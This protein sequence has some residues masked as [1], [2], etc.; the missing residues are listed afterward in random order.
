MRGSRQSIGKYVIFI[1]SPI[2]M[3]TNTGNSNVEQLKTIVDIAKE[4]AKLAE[5]LDDE[6]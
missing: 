6:S 5:D 4:E 2:R 3:T 1:F